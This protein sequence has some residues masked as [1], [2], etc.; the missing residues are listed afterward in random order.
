MSSG[1]GRPSC[2]G[3]NVL[4]ADF[5]DIDVSKEMIIIFPLFC[6]FVWTSECLK[7]LDHQVYV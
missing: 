7:L 3:L 1:K 5:S 6:S 4:A 2:L